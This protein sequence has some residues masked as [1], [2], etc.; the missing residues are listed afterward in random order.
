MPIKTGTIWETAPMTPAM[1]MKNHFYILSLNRFLDIG[2]LLRT[3]ID[4]KN[5]Q[6]H[7]RMIMCD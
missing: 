4:Q 6:M 2:H 5:D 3:L 1:A 7:I